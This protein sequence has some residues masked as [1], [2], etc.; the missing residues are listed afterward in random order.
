MAYWSVVVIVQLLRC[1]WLIEISWTAA[2]QASLSI[3]NSQILLKL[4]SIKSV[5]PSNR[6]ILC[7]P[8]FLLPSIFPA[9]ESFP[10]KQLF[11]S[12]G[13]ILELQF[14]YQSFQ[15]IFRLIS[16]RIYWFDLLAVQ[17]TLKSLL[18][19]HCSKA[20]ILQRSAFFM[21][22]LLKPYM[23]SGKA[24]DLTIWICVNKVMSLLF[25]ILPRFVIIFL[26]RSKCLLVSW[27][28]SWSAEILELFSVLR[29]LLCFPTCILSA[30][31]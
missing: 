10:V 23:T 5:I 2:C 14:Q 16:F 25:N 30:A 3:T 17:G 19:H 28:Q 24:I 13:K 9:S 18:Q 8:L 7:H 21:V 15:W 1:V 12:G 29:P 22:H 4:M 31:L 27:L 6:L 26:P 11:A 20:S